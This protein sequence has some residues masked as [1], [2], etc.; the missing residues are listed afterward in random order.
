MSQTNNN[1]EIKEQDT[2][3]EIIWEGKKDIP[4]FLLYWITYIV[5]LCFFYLFPRLF[6][7][8]IDYKWFIVFL[9]FF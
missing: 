6:N 8:E 1:T 7:K 5:F 3:D 9:H 4:S 2:Q